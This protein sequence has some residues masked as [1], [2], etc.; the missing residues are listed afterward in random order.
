MA[1]RLLA[2]VLAFVLVCLPAA[3]FDTPD[4]LIKDLYGPYLDNQVPDDLS[5][6]FSDDL[7][8]QWIA[9][10]ERDPYGL[11]FDPVID[12]QDFTITELEV[13]DP[14]VYEDGVEIRV[15]FLNFVA[16]RSLVYRLVQQAD[17]WAVDDIISEGENVWRLRELIAQ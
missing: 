17:G 3:A 2:T 14:A 10:A 1:I 12:G 15:S 9:L 16:P 6:Y 5:V 4:A 8:A 11:G 13:S 7:E